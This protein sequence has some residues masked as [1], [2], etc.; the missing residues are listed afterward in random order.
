NWFVKL[1]FHRRDIPVWMANR[2]FDTLI[3]QIDE[4]AG[5]DTFRWVRVIDRGRYADNLRFYVLVS[6]LRS[7]SKY[8]WILLWQEL[9]A[10][11]RRHC[12]RRLHWWRDQVHF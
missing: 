10:G 3:A 8:R 1:T 5:L 6:G 7:A 11:R 12:V 9:L 2:A 4:N